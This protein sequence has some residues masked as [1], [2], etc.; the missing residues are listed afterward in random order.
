MCVYIYIY[1]H[2]HTYIYTCICLMCVQS[3]ILLSSL[4]ELPAL[5]PPNAAGGAQHML[6]S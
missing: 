1:I 6:K 2:T 3:L 5:L 4:A